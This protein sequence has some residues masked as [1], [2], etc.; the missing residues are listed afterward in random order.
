M[1]LV[2]SL[3]VGMALVLSGCGD[4][5]GKVDKEATVPPDPNLKPA[6]VGSPNLGGGAPAGKTK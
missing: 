3:F 6:N 5:R 2:L 4:N 1:R